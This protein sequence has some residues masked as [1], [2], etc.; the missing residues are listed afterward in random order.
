M[1]PILDG[2]STPITQHLHPGSPGITPKDR[3]PANH[4]YTPR[5][6]RRVHHGGLTTS[7]QGHPPQLGPWLKP[8]FQP[9][10]FMFH[11]PTG[12][13][14]RS[15]S[16]SRQL[17][18]PP[19]LTLTRTR[20]PRIT[21][22]SPVPRATNIH[23]LRT[24][25]QAKR[26]TLFFFF[27][28]ISPANHTLPNH[29]P[30]Y[31]GHS[32]YGL[33]SAT[34]IR[35][36]TDIS[37]GPGRLS[38]K[39]SVMMDPLD[40]A[41]PPKVRD[42]IWAREYVD[43]AALLLDDEQEMELRICNR[44]DKPSF[45]M[46]PRHKQDITNIGLWHKAFRR[47][48][49]VYLRKYP[50]EHWGIMTYIDTIAELADDG[51]D[52]VAYDK[53]FRKNHA[54]GREAYGN[55]NVPMYIQ[56]AKSCFRRNASK[57]ANHSIQGATAS[58]TMMVT[59][60]GA[61]TT[62][63]NATDAKARTPHPSAP[64][65]TRIKERKP[66]MS[67]R[68]PIKIDALKAYLQ[69][70][71]RVKTQYLLDGFSQGFM[72][73]SQGLQSANTDVKNPSIPNQ[74]VA[75]VQKKLQKEIDAGRIIGPFS[76]PPLPNFR[77]SP[78][79]VAEK[80]EP[81]KYRFIHNLSYPYDEDSVNASIPRDKVAVQYSTIDDAIAYIKAVGRGAFLAKTDIKSAFRIIPVHPSQYHLLGMRWKGEYF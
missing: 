25:F 1:G 61:A 48:A 58:L 64:Q 3:R 17:L 77:V 71:D 28:F 45:K 78:I 23:H 11:Q 14:K 80:K 73:Q 30:P 18:R 65:K 74:L 38:D 24:P 26:H 70:Y 8:N 36:G 47:Y 21:S 68:T 59:G 19:T 41:V 79:K 31:T 75:E 69:G 46:V 62:S 81:G 37:R 43:L 51:V 63:T 53:R 2:L 33:D 44:Q 42:K 35:E 72:L 40:G 32:A 20:I 55:V 6:G 50:Y 7:L 54:I 57:G 22:H 27:F 66:D 34:Y 13:V 76:S 56:A 12:Q 10:P 9:K 16:R 15:S 49:T 52:W 5:P 4:L 39:L 67:E 60:A 29:Q